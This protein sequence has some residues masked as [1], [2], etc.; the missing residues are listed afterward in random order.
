[1]RWIQ[2]D[3]CIVVNARLESNKKEQVG[4]LA[5]ICPYKGGCKALKKFDKKLQ[6]AVN[7]TFILHM[8]YAEPVNARIEISRLPD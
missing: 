7:E 3:I 6:G 2:K 8:D 1:M 5:N 4:C